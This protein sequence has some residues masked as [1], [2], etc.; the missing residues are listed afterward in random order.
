[1]DLMPTQGDPP[2]LGERNFDRPVTLDTPLSTDQSTVQEPELAEIGNEQPAFGESTRRRSR[3]RWLHCLWRWPLAAASGAVDLASL[4]VLIALVAAIPLVQF[5][6]LGYLLYA[7]ARLANGGS[8]RRALP[9]I[10]TAGRLGVFLLIA[11]ILYLPVLLVADLAY[12]MQLLEP[13]ST[14]AL[15]WQ[16]SSGFLW[17]AW[18]LHVAWAAARGG[19]WWHL[20]WPAPIRFVKQGWRPGVW[21]QSLDDFYQLLL[22]MQLPRLWWLGARATVAALLFL[23]I[24]CSLMIIGQRA[25]E[26]PVAP[27]LGVLGAIG[28]V[29]VM[30]TLPFL[31]IEFAR[32]GRLKGFLEFGKVR[33]RFR[34]AP[35]AHTIALVLLCVLSIPLY[36]LRIEAVP[37]EILWAPS[38]IFASLMLPAKLFL[39]WAIGRADRKIVAGQR[40]SRWWVRFPCRIVGLAG[41]LLYVGSLYVAQ[42]VAGQGAWVMYFQH[43][44]LVPNPLFVA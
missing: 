35:M 28:M 7:A 15:G 4:I 16:L 10:G 1:M 2:I 6:S 32:Q 8:W 41:V 21:K 19:R 34:M 9:G 5:I 12:S 24:P 31:Q 17:M 29:A 11:S 26:L 25:Q 42:L 18:C 30:F 39:G 43:A 38:I 27:F 40:V 36:L 3:F 33:Q 23:A 44:F 13:G 37:Q 22:S 14:K 20:L